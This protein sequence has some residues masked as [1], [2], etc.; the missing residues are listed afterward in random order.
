MNGTLFCIG[1][2]PGDPELLT[3]KAVRLLER[4]PV[5]A[6]PKTSGGRSVALSIAA[7]AVKPG[8][9][10]MLPLSFPMTRDPEKQDE[11]YRRAAE[12]LCAC[13]AGGQDAALLTLGDVSIYSTA[14]HVLARVEQR[15]FPVEIC[16][17]VPS[18]SA[19]AAALHL[20][21]TQRREP[22]LVLPADHPDLAALLR[23]PG[24][25]VLLKAGSRL[26][27]LKALLKEAGLLE[28]TRAVLDCGMPTQRLWHS[29]ADLPDALGYF[30]TLIVPEGQG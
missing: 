16:A 25:K 24:T 23:F 9:R 21:L 28:K 3:R 26:P 20:P 13:L 7:Q 15:G 30:L 22:L 1:V 2:G 11:S 5:W 14:G 18:F 4:C 29:A 19:A 12:A 27:E 17:G 6:A 10:R 8:T